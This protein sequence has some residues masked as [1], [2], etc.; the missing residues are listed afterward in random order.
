MRDEKKEKRRKDD[1]NNQT[2]ATYAKFPNLPFPRSSIGKRLDM[3][4]VYTR[5]LQKPWLWNLRKYAFNYI[6]LG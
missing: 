2:A 6:N 3:S 5:C 4:L 1:K